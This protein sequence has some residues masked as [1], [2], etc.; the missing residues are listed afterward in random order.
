MVDVLLKLKA[1]LLLNLTFNNFLGVF[2]LIIEMVLRRIKIDFN[3]IIDFIELL[4]SRS[5]SNHLILHLLLAAFRFPNFLD[6]FLNCA[7]EN[8]H[9]IS[10]NVKESDTYHRPPD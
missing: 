7:H 8:N 4:D 10:T 1:C 6:H 5:Y 9:Y 2:F 3:L